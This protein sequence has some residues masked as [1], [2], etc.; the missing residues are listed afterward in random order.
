MKSLLLSQ[1]KLN[2]INVIFNVFP[3]LALALCIITFGVLVGIS[4]FYLLSASII[5]IGLVILYFVA[6][7]IE[8]TNETLNTQDS[9]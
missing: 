1:C 8:C 5:A 4:H 6:L 2:N 7:L 9:I 3:S